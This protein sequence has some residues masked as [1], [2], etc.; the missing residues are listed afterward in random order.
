MND[1]FR[2]VDIPKIPDHLIDTLAAFVNR[3]NI[4]DV[5]KSYYL[6]FEISK[7]LETFLKSIFD[8]KITAQYQIIKKGLPI[9]KDRKRTECFNYLIETG[10]SDTCLNTYDEDKET[11]LHSVHIEPFKWHWINVGKFHG[12]SGLTDAPRLAISVTPLDKKIQPPS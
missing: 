10:G 7:E 4:Y 1:F 11:V 6:Q 9:H 3:K 5:E 2:Y 8:F 12:V